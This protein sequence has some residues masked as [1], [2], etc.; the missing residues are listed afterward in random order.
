MDKHSD[1]NVRIKSELEKQ[2]C[3]FACLHAHLSIVHDSFLLCSSHKFISIGVFFVALLNR[4]LDVISIYT[5][6]NKHTRR[7]QISLF[8]GESNR[9]RSQW[10][11]V[12]TFYTWNTMSKSKRTQNRCGCGSHTH[13]ERLAHTTNWMIFSLIDLKMIR[14]SDDKLQFH[15]KINELNW[16][17]FPFISHSIFLTYWLESIQFY[18][19]AK[20]YIVPS[21]ARSLF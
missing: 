16:A 10:A 12:E 2:N 14:F 19:I 6:A 15:D 4:L 1:W 9:S 20:K 17:L 21:T 5:H 18:Q 11:K 3:L 7:R 8:A 13:S